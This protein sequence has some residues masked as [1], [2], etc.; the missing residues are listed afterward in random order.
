MGTFFLLY[1]STHSRPKAAGGVIMGQDFGQPEFQHTAARRRLG[2]LRWRNRSFVWFQHTAARRRLDCIW[3]R[4]SLSLLFQHTAA[5]RRLVVKFM[6]DLNRYK[7]S[8]H[9]RPKA[10]GRHIHNHISK[11]HRFNTQPPEGG[12]ARGQTSQ[13]P[14]ARF[15]TQPPE[16]GWE[17]LGWGNVRRRSFNT[18]P[19]EGGWFG[20]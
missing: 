13:R 10:A 5:R 9:S 1:V 7:V 4:D 6:A 14:P 11:S 16:G 12:W 15:N 3:A 2:E 17:V 8:T 19:P 20:H 18:Q